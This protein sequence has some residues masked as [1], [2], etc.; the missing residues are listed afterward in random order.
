[1]FQGKKWQEEIDTRD[2]IFN[3]ITPYDGDES[4]LSKSSKKPRN[5]GSN[6]RNFSRKS[7]NL[8][9]AF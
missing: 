1:M 9:A 6:A 7:G 3:I 2:F 4:F 5:F 8:L